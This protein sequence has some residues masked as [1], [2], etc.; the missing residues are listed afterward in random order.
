[1]PPFR[2]YTL[3]IIGIRDVRGQLFEDRRFV[4]EQLN[5]H[6]QKEG[7]DLTK[8]QIIT[9]GG[10]GVES[11]VMEWAERR[12]VTYRRVPPNV[13]E[14]GPQLAFIDRNKTIAYQSAELLVFWDGCNE[15]VI[16]AITVAARAGRYVR[17]IPLI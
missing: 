14:L 12:N 2:P 5:E 4:D 1:M 8:T 3:G 9:G 6:V 17:V 13:Q 16:A 10:K 11:L 15:S 7:I